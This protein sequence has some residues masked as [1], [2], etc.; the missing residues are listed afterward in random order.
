MTSLSQQLPFWTRLRSELFNNPSIN[1]EEWWETEHEET[2]LVGE[3]CEE[4]DTFVVI[5]SGLTDLKAKVKDNNKEV[6]GPKGYMKYDCNINQ[7]LPKQAY[8][9]VKRPLPFAYR[10]NETYVVDLTVVSGGRTVTAPE[11]FEKVLPDLNK[12]CGGDF[13][14]ICQKRKKNVCRVLDVAVA[15][16]EPIPPLGFQVVNMNLNTTRSLAPPAYLCFCREVITHIE[17]VE[18]EISTLLSESSLFEEISDYYVA[19]FP[20]LKEGTILPC[21]LFKKG[22]LVDHPITAIKICKVDSDIP[23]SYSKLKQF[24]YVNM[25]TKVFLERNEE[26]NSEFIIDLQIVP[27]LPSVPTGYSYLEFFHKKN[28]FYLCYDKAITLGEGVDEQIL[29]DIAIIDTIQEIEEEY[30]KVLDIILTQETTDEMRL[31]KINLPELAGMKNCGNSCYIDSTIFS[32]FALNNT[33]AK[34]LTVPLQVEKLNQRVLQHQLFQITNSI[35]KGE[36]ISEKQMELLRYMMRQNSWEGGLNVPANTGPN[37][38]QQ[39]A[40]ELMQMLMNWLDMPQL[41]LK[42]LITHSGLPTEDDETMEGLRV[43][44]V[45][46]PE[47]DKK[48]TIL[49]VDTFLQEFFFNNTPD[50]SIMRFP[51]ELKSSKDTMIATNCE[52]S[53]RLIPQYMHSKSSSNDYGYPSKDTWSPV[54]NQGQYGSIV[55]PVVLK[56]FTNNLRK[57]KTRVLVPTVISANKFL[58]NGGLPENQDCM[59]LEEEE[60]DTNKEKRIFRLQSIICHSGDTLEGGHYFSY[61][62]KDAK[63]FTE[64]LIIKEKEENSKKRGETE[65]NTERDDNV[66]KQRESRELS[67]HQIDMLL[68]QWMNRFPIPVEQADRETVKIDV[69]DSFFIDFQCYEESRPLTFNL[70]GKRGILLQVGIEVGYI[71]AIAYIDGSWKRRSDS[72]EVEARVKIQITVNNEYYHITTDFGQTIVYPHELPIE[73]VNCLYFGGAGY[74]HSFRRVH[75][76]SLKAVYTRDLGG[77]EDAW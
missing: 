69:G 51:S 6:V 40:E 57:N 65:N 75:D 46:F 27:D 61:S 21:L 55:V 71:S 42:R 10:I 30:A 36:V 59:E 44:S 50:D 5:L 53:Y 3:V 14:F 63:S 60:V 9:F 48:S 23:R 64:D 43:L 45:S 28:P 74:V 1:F 31:E 29:K 19:P 54:K 16:N 56:R 18:L 13:V 70:G 22:L 62:R 37:A 15:F 12:R 32:L 24:P 11:H 38:K 2:I 41:G 52:I 39:D 66:H 8:L 76:D 25:K 47:K 67:N 17:Y 7:G 49:N 68:N 73:N 35:R 58:L 26:L 72:I 4:Y 77:K 33:F 34:M 20:F